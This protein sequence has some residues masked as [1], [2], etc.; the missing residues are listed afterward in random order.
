MKFD[1]EAI[2]NSRKRPFIPISLRDPKTKATVECWAL[3]DSC[4]DCN[5]FAPVLGEIM[6][7][8]IE[9]GVQRPIG[10][11]VAGEGRSFFEHELEIIVGGW[12][13]I[14]KVGFMPNISSQAGE[15]IVGQTGFFDHFNFVKF[16]KR[17]N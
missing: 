3:V 9:H 10:G 15:G 2:G 16:D 8:D 5:W 4:A 14:T 7:I 11:V 6:G 13:F 12:A 1:Y 17:K